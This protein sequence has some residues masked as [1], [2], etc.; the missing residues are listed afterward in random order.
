MHTRVTFSFHT[1]TCRRQRTTSKVRLQK[2][3]RSYEDTCSEHQR[4]CIIVI[5]QYTRKRSAKL[6]NI[7]LSSLGSRLRGREWGMSSFATFICLHRAI[8]FGIQSLLANRTER[9]INMACYLSS[10]CQLQAEAC[11]EADSKVGY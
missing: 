5:P 11:R 3:H 2:R 6:D 8:S 1:P 10:Y 4:R 7:Q 9:L